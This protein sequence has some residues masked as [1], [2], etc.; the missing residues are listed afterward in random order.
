[1]NEDAHPRKPTCP[2]KRDYMSVGNT[3]CNHLMDMSVFWG[4]SPTKKIVDFPS[5]CYFDRGI[6]TFLELEGP[7]KNLQANHEEISTIRFSEGG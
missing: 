7:P 4:V 2:L 1:M 6:T 5:S 3:S